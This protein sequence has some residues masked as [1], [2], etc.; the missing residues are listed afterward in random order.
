LFL[1]PGTSPL[2][3]LLFFPR[4]LFFTLRW[5]IVSRDFPQRRVVAPLIYG[6]LLCNSC[7]IRGPDASAPSIF[8]PQFSFLRWPV[9]SWRFQAI[10]NILG[11]Q[12]LQTV[13]SHDPFFPHQSL[14]VLVSPCFF[15]SLLSL[16]F[17][18]CPPGHFS[19]GDGSPPRYSRLWS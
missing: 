7:L 18:P 12:D 4:L 2:L 17:F 9:R 13:F 19:S 10:A 8:F 16:S 15:L 5:S 1:R 14:F 3:L 11:Q 6:L